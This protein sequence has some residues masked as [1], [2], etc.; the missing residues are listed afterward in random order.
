VLCG[1]VMYDAVLHNREVARRESGIVRALGLAATDYGV[2]TLHRAS[3]TTPEVLPQLLRALAEIATDTLPL[4]FPLHPRTRAA[5]GGDV[6]AAGR[7]IQVIDPVG[8]IDMLSLVDNARIVLTDSGGLQKEAAFLEKPCVTLRETTEW[9][10]TVTMG[11]NRLAGTDPSRIREAVREFLDGGGLPRDAW[12]E[13]VARHYGDGQAARAIHRH[14][15][16]WM[17]GLKGAATR[18][19]AAR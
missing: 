11:A 17:K 16:E 5:L 9:V 1:D 12:R 19:V 10:E 13:A 6:R 14:L 3:N 15:A 4:V 2:L 7:A 18:A 8:Y